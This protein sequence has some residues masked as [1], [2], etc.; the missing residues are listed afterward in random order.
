VQETHGLL[1]CAEWTGVRL[2]TVLGAA[3][4]RPEAAWFVAE[5]ADAAAMDR[6]IPLADALRIGAL[7]AYSQNGEALRPEQ[8]FPL[9][10]LLPGFEGNTSVKWLRHIALRRGPAMSKEETAYY[11]QLLPNGKARAFNFVMEAKSVITFPS[12]GQSLSERGFYEI[13]GLAWSGNGPVR[14]VDVS[15]DGGKNWQRAA[16]Q[17][18]VLPRALT[19]FR[20]PWRWNGGRAVLQSRATD[21]TGYVQ[22]TRQE[23][24]A[25]RGA[26]S[27]YHYNAIQSWE[28]QPDGE[29]VNVHV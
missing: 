29:V 24:M 10:L 25:Y 21:E 3:G 23:L 5:G 1:S 12:A 7:L 28:V 8:G 6:S 16:L 20:L 2:E 11:T 17:E 27:H 26:A 4:V 13:R 14:V 15:L 19:R 18:P 22:P 9:R